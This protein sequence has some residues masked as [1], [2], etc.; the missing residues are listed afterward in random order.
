M[1]SLQQL[2]NEKA[3][4]NNVIAHSFSIGWALERA[5]YLDIG[6]ENAKTLGK[7]LKHGV[8]SQGIATK[9]RKSG[10][11]FCHLAG[12]YRRGGALALERLITELTQDGKV[13]VTNDKA[14]IKSI[15]DY[16]DNV[17]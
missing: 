4:K 9:I 7:L 13:R 2:F 14:I 5:A 10:L 1:K 16:F 11:K 8:V 17:H 3:N 15:C 12:T 6:K